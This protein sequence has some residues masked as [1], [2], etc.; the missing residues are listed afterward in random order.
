M[1]AILPHFNLLGQLKVT[2][3]WYFSSLGVNSRQAGPGCG[4]PTEVSIESL[5]RTLIDVGPSL[6]T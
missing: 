6:L 1:L 3:P 4:N 5:F 2:I